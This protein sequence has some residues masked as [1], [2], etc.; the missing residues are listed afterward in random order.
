[1]E[2]GLSQGN[3]SCL[4][5]DSRGF[6]WIGTQDGLNRF[7]GYTFRHFQ[8]EPGNPASLSNNYIWCLLEDSQGG[9]WVGTFDG[10]ICRFD[11]ETETFKTFPLTGP[12]HPAEAGN[13][14]RSLCEFPKGTLW[15]GAD[16]G[17]W[18]LDI[19]T[20]EL[21]KKQFP[22]AKTA[23]SGLENVVALH[24][25]DDKQLLAGAA[26]GLFQINFLT[27][28]MEPVNLSQEPVAATAIVPAADDFFWVGTQG[29]LFQL[30][31]FAQNDSLAVAAHFSQHTNSLNSLPSNIINSLF[32]DGKNTLWIGTN[33]GLSRFDTDRPTSGFYNFSHEE[34]NPHSLVNDMVFSILEVEPG[35][36]WTGTREGVS[37]FSNQPPPFQNLSFEG[38]NGALCSDAVLGMLEDKED[39]LWVGTRKGLTR[40][41]HF[42]KGKE[43]WEIEC[44]TP[45]NTPSMPF[46]YVINLFQN[47]DGAIWCAFRRNGIA[48]LKKGDKGK[49]FFQSEKSIQSLL[50]G[51]GVNA[52]NFDDDKIWL[53]T[54]GHGLVKWD[55]TLGRHEVFTDDG[56]SNLKHNYIFCLKEDS[57]GRLWLGTANGGLC[58]FDKKTNAFTCYV[59]DDAN[60]HSLSNNMVLSIFEDSR[61]HLWACTANGLNLMGSDGRFQRFFKKDGL[62]NDVVYGLLEDGEGNIWA[63]TNQGLSKISFQNGVFKTQNFTTA[64]GLPG[65]EFNQHAFLKT[66]DGK[67]LFGGTDGLVIFDPKTIQPNA[68]TPPVALTDFQ[69]FGQTQGIGGILKK[70]INETEEITLPYHQNFIALEYAALGFRQAENIEYAYMLV[71]LDEDWVQ[72]GNRR[73]ANYP[74]LPPGNYVFKVKA[75]NHD[76]IWNEAPKALKIRILPPW[77]RTWWAYL[78]YALSVGGAV[79]L[80]FKLRVESVRRI[81]RTKVAE[82]ERF[83]E[84]MARDFHDEAGNKITKISLLTEI[85]RRQMGSSGVLEPLLAQ[86]E[87]N[88]QELRA[89]MRDFIWVLDPVNDNLYDTLMRL[90]DFGNGLFAYSSTSF[91]TDGIQEPL[92]PVPLDGSQRRHLLLIFKEAMNNCVKYAEANEAV[93][94]VKKRGDL[95]ELQFSDDGKGFDLE[96]TNSGNGLKNMRARAE[97]LGG[98]FSIRT[99]PGQG[100][101]I[102]WSLK[103][104]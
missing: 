31:Y 6:L 54:P 47:D 66:R 33:E 82:R 97:K 98:E 100:T 8:H 79:F 41:G 99:K 91:S 16:K 9:I 81:E 45:S 48:Q 53:G 96:K 57:K 7:D 67:L 12:T 62:P 17:I 87:E 65:N 1:M 60:A 70:A 56:S 52:M 76:G 59:Q 34:S 40:I 78:L 50:G 104:L 80:I 95:L 74:K 2:E 86:M 30:K 68:Y 23:V 89:G 29:G 102:V 22:T 51:A 28:K 103:T 13:A 18:S 11:R 4:M 69:L 39:N 93:L 73:F 64:N 32:Y 77:W 3:A 26:Q 37:M 55:H 61:Q 75:A 92:R 63:S 25:L 10:N 72:A 83:R 14:V 85:V 24:P 35:L 38:T 21:R 58:C 5:K 88:I 49:R 84:R 46:D 101:T 42:S 36:L 90:K 43:K 44:L 15:L 27:N 94:S 71:G 19:K 20:N